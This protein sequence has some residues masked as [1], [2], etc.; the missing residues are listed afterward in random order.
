LFYQNVG[1]AEV[2]HDC[3]YLAEMNSKLL[4][5]IEELT[6][7]MLKRKKEMDEPKILVG[8]ISK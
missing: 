6:L 8:K 2:K 5:K 1:G 4:A 7:Y 3:I